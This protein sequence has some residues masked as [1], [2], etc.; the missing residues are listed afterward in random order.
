[1]IKI[2]A[3]RMEMNQIVFQK[4]GFTVM[5]KLMTCCDQRL[6][7]ALNRNCNV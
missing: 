3:L 4:G 6:L 1:M 7:A 2:N 5:V